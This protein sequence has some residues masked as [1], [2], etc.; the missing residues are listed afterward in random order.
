MYSFASNLFPDVSFARLG[1]IPHKRVFL[2]PVLPAEQVFGDFAANFSESRLKVEETL[3]LAMKGRYSSDSEST[4]GPP[5]I[6]SKDHEVPGTINSR[7][8]E[9]QREVLSLPSILG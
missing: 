9:Y 3:R 8:R 6:L 4:Q 1:M 2:I 5:L 7:L